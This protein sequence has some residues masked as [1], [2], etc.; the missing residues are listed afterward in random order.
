[1]SKKDLTEV[2]DFQARRRRAQKMKRFKGKI[3]AA[4]KRLRTRVA[5]SNHLMK[6]ARR[7]AIKFMRR[8]IA[9]KLGLHYNELSVAQKMQID[10]KIQAKKAVIG[11]IAQRLM[12]KI[13]QAEQQRV[14]SMHSGTP[15]A[16]PKEQNPNVG[17]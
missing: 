3:M 14:Q 4:R 9:G 16:K 12:P 8:R 17:F 2:L 7:M 13:R 11:K 1:M 6:R 5:D 10:L 15:T